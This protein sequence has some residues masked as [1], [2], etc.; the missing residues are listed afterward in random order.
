MDRLCDVGLYSFENEM[1][2]ISLF[3]NFVN[4]SAIELKNSFKSENC[5]LYSNF[6]V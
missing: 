4:L 2:Q 1:L 3:K 6:K 5:Q